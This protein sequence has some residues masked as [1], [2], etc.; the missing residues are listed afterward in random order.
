M[1]SPIDSFVDKLPS[2][3]IDPIPRKVPIVYGRLI[4]LIAGE[5]L[6]SCEASCLNDTIRELITE[7]MKD[8]D[9]IV[10]PYV[11]FDT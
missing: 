9:T 5:K 4:R 3:I 1:L 2:T 11:I 8:K 6:P 7:V 10:K